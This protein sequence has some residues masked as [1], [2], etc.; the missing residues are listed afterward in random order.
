MSQA[1]IGCAFCRFRNRDLDAAT[2]PVQR[3]IQSESITF[4]SEIVCLR[5]G[6]KRSFKVPNQEVQAATEKRNRDAHQA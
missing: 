6:W 2:K 5:C 4:L 3:P 1:D